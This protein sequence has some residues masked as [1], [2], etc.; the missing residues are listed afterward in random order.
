MNPID[1]KPLITFYGDDTTG[2]VAVMDILVSYG[3]KAVVFLDAPTSEQLDHFKEYHAIGQA[4]LAR[5]KDNAWM[6]KHLTCDFKKLKE[7]HAPIFHY[8]TCSTLGS[9]PNIGSIGRAIEIGADIFGGNSFIFV[10]GAPAIKR[11]QL[12]GNLFA[13]NDQFVYRLDR[14]PVMKNHPVTPMHESDVGMHLGKQTDMPIRNVNILDLFNTENVV[15]ETP[16]IVLLDILDEASLI[17]AGEIINNTMDKHIFCAGSQGIEYALCAYWQ[18]IGK[19]QKPVLSDIKPAASMLGISGS[20]SNVTKAQILYARKNKVFECL[21]LDLTTLDETQRLTEEIEKQVG[22]ALSAI[23]EKKTPLIYS[24]LGENEDLSQE[25]KE[26]IGE[27]L[28]EITYQI[29]QKTTVERVVVAG[30]DTSGYVSERLG[31]YALSS[32]NTDPGHGGLCLAFT[33]QSKSFEI[34]FKGGQMGAESYF[35]IMKYG[36]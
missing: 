20:C 19:L 23:E 8:K 2:T 11:Y 25:Q 34:A 29:T 4:S 1:T 21:E 31:I 6:D 22:L 12:F 10:A 24:S 7:L 28:G 32:L 26:R 3:L 5:A 14:H 16:G 35:E 27:T 33:S 30:G 36:N 13:V 17:K 15:Q 18:S 9:S